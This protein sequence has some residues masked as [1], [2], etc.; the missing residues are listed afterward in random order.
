[1]TTQNFH[2][3]RLK[4]GD[5]V[6]PWRIIESLGSGNF[7]R[8]FK[9]ERDGELFTLKMA[10]RPAPQLPQPTPE[11]TLEE[12]QVDARMGHEAAVLITNSSHSGLPHLR[13]VDRWPHATQGF[14]YFVTDYVPGEPFH[15]WRAQACPTAAQLVDLFIEVVRGIAQLHGRGVLIR[16]FKSEHVIVGPGNKPVVV[17][18]G[19]AWLPGASTLT[20]GL[21][22][23]TPYALPPECIA[24]IREGAWKQGARFDADVTGDLYQVGVF[25]YEALADGWPFNPKLGHAALM[26]A[27]EH[28]VPR[29]PHRINP[30]VPQSLS[31]IALKLLEKRPQE[32]Y[33]SAEALLQA[34][35]EAAKERSQPG[36]KVPLELP[37]SGPA[38][39]TQEEVDERRVREEE[40]ERR[41][42]EE[43]PQKLSE[44]QARAQLSLLTGAIQGQLQLADEKA[45]R[46]KRRWRRIGG[47]AGALLLG[48]MLFV[49]WQVWRTPVEA[50]PP[51]SEKGNPFV[52]TLR[53][54]PPVRATLAWLCTTFS[55]G[56]AAPQLRPPPGDCPPEVVRSMKEMGVIS[57]PKSMS[58]VLDINQP[59]ETDQEGLYRPG[60]I[61]S[62]V[63][64]RRWSS[65]PLPEGTLLYGQLWMEGLTKEGDPAVLGRYT[66][67]LLPDGRR[68]PICFTLGM[69]GLI[70]ALEYKPGEATLPREGDAL[71]VRYWP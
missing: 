64:T 20:V 2:P 19:S 16:D 32:R 39:V 30:Q 57:D 54:S 62:K 21:A 29:A 8:A 70:R 28:V 3:D 6:G 10:L 5:M 50:W 61:V 4:P 43:P 25:M 36:W 69:T 63:V 55:V 52:S 26:A 59:G 15:A 17:D 68:F 7:G 12:R 24:F 13:A 45:A 71:P 37:A 44:E 41:A 23:G 40:A 65:N 33:P 46:S 34:L 48:L 47:G 9:A 11:K 58:V 27:I 49:A 67:A 53:N 42:Q 56:C 14:L 18:M 22:P 60:P 51:V 66:E 1:M 38:P 31:L 35:W